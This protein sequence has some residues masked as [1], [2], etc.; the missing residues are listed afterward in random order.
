MKTYI[1][2]LIC[3]II[4]SNVF[5]FCY[6]QEKIE[7]N[8]NYSFNVVLDMNHMS[9]RNDYNYKFLINKGWD[10]DENGLFKLLDNKTLYYISFEYKKA[11]EKGFDHY[12]RFPKDTLKV[13]LT[14]SQIDSIFVLTT[15]LM[16]IDKNLNITTKKSPEMDYDGAYA[17]VRLE[18]REYSTINEIIISF[19]NE[20]IYQKRFNC[21][22][23]FLNSIKDN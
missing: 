2:K 3:L 22:L 14:D 1:T 21:L 5:F 18:L 7:N 17:S 13:I 9:R 6:S 15:E 19:V 11:F 4:F 8:K 20:D 10:Y 23:E 12:D 16:T